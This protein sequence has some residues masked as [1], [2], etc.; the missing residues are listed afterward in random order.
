VR[1]TN[2]L[3]LRGSAAPAA[4]TIPNVLAAGPGS[5]KR[6][7]GAACTQDSDGYGHFRATAQVIV[8]AVGAASHQRT[9]PIAPFMSI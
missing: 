2:A 8:M 5:S 6:W 9:S 7:L 3:L 1:I 4:A